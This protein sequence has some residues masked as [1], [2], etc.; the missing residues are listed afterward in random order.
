MIIKQKKKQRTELKGQG[1]KEKTRPP[2]FILPIIY[3]IKHTALH[4]SVCV[5]VCALYGFSLPLQP[6]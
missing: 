4:V 3:Q 6:S 2:E 1:G 5:C